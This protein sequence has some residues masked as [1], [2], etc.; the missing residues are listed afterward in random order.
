MLCIGRHGLGGLEEHAH[1]LAGLG[2][3]HSAVG[4][5]GRGVEVV[6]VQRDQ[7][8]DRAGRLDD[9]RG[10]ARRGQALAAGPRSHPDPLHLAHLR[11][12]R[13]DLRL[14]DDLAALDPGEPKPSGKEFRLG[15]GLK[16][17]IS[18]DDAKG[19]GEFNQ[20][21]GVTFPTLLDESKRGY[22]VSNEFG[23]T[24]VPSLFLVETDGSISKSF[25]GFSKRDLEQLGE[26]M[27]VKPFQ[28]DEKV[29]E[30]KAG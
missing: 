12:D 18:Q 3:P 17:G 19:T 15:V 27:R 11:R 10:H 9:D 26:R 30:F 28:P 20:R 16:Q 8:G 21:F 5:A 24:S 7:R 13:A 25:S 23:I 14:E 29:P 22:P 4:R 6:D 1:Q 2:E